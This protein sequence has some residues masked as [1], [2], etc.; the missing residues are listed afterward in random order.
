[1]WQ[2]E[3]ET[4]PPAVLAKRQAKRLQQ[5][6]SRMALHVEFYRRVL[7]ERGVEPGAVTSL[8][9]LEHLPFTTRADLRA[10][11]PLGLL[12][13]PPSRINRLHATSGTKGKPTL[14]AYSA[15]DLQTWADI[16]ARMLVA[17]GCHPGDLW[18][19]ASGYGLFTGGLG[20]HYGAERAGAAVVPVSSGNTSRLLQLA[21]DLHPKGIHCIPSYMLRV[22]EVAGAS[23]IDPRSFGLRYGS[24]GGETWTE[25]LRRRIEELFG[26]TAFDV[27]GLSECFG[28]GVGYECQAHDGLHLSE[29]HFLAEI[30]DPA[31]GKP[32]PDGE[33]G[34]LVL[35]T[36]TKEAMP[37]LRYRTGDLTRFL[38]GR[39]A[40]GRTF[41]RIAGITGRTDDM[42]IVRGVNLF[43]SEVERVLMAIPGLGEQYRLVLERTGPMDSLTVEAEL[44]GCGAEPE[45]LADEAHRQLKEQLGVSAEVRLL[46][47]GALPRSEGKAV[48]VL[49]Q[50]P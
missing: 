18:F 40:C 16:A 23:G 29:D 34:E 1:M 25:P 37:L 12:A 45:G 9:A 33:M 10:Q 46:A 3:I 49:D 47:P 27:Y 14:V 5:L 17:A 7:A 43:P 6:V 44:A 2:K 41:R 32:V 31:T 28:P 38:Q 4:A 30:I 21:A 24:F 48:R 8:A 39:C 42:L 13:V 35:T 50:R 22:A 36:L 15:R 11:Y 20:A 19:V 26:L